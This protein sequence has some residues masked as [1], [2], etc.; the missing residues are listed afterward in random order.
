ACRSIADARAASSTTTASGGIEMDPSSVVAGLL[1]ASSI[2]GLSAD[3]RETNR[4]VTVW[5][6]VE[7]AANS[8]R[9]LVDHHDRVSRMEPRVLL[10]N[11]CNGISAE[12]A[13]RKGQ[14]LID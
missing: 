5:P 7:S 4:D 1:L 3:L 9:W 13:R 14:Q 6:N 10:I 11:F 12:E 2:P 8:D